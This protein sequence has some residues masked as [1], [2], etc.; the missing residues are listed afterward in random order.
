MTYN[1]KHRWRDR[2][3]ERDRQRETKKERE[4]DRWREREMEKN[5]KM[6]NGY[7]LLQAKGW[8]GFRVQMR[9]TMFLIRLFKYNISGVRKIKVELQEYGSFG[10][11]G[12]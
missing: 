10:N 11:I 2:E 7:N 1:I 12:H 9:G 3:R 6:E 5:G 4:R 8:S